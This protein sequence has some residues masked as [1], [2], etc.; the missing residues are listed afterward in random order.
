MINTV[1]L[2]RS[3]FNLNQ[4]TWL[5]METHNLDS[6]IRILKNIKNSRSFWK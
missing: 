5:E 4:I 2:F 6:G 3:R 1:W